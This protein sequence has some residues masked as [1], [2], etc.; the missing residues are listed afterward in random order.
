[1]ILIDR[2]VPTWNQVDAGNGGIIKR[3]YLCFQLPLRSLVLLT[4]LRARCVA[5]SRATP[6]SRSDQQA[7]KCIPPTK[8]FR[9]LALVV[10]KPHLAVVVL[11][12]LALFAIPSLSRLSRPWV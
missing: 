6:S 7:P 11:K 4:L 2:R 12:L 9:H 1:M 5:I 3:C 8:A 10:L